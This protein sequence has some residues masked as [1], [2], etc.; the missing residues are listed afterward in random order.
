MSLE[1]KDTCDV[2]STPQDL[3]NEKNFLESE[4]LKKEKE[5]KNEGKESEETKDKKEEAEKDEAQKKL[6]VELNKV[7]KG[8]IFSSQI[9][10]EEINKKDWIEQ[11][12]DFIRKFFNL[13]S[14]NRSDSFYDQF[15]EGIR[16]DLKKADAE[17]YK[18]VPKKYNGIQESIVAGSPA[19]TIQRTLKDRTISDTGGLLNGKNYPPV[20]MANVVIKISG[21]EAQTVDARCGNPNERSIGI[22][23][24]YEGGELPSFIDYIQKNHQELWGAL[25]DNFRNIL[26]EAVKRKD[27]RVAFNKEN[28]GKLQKLFRDAAQQQVEFKASLIEDFVDRIHSIAQEYKVP[29]VAQAFLATEEGVGFLADNYNHLGPG[30]VMR[31]FRETCKALQGREVL[32]VMDVLQTYHQIYSGTKGRKDRMARNQNFMDS[33]KKV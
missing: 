6:E 13:G 22:F 18:G 8:E 15:D 9:P 24:F 25:D 27:F 4:N 19:E 16:S 1:A 11:I 32:T 31:F 29:S 28:L 5:Q 21:H 2:H 3:K 20:S 12:V 10:K 7:K 26:S 14:V 30:G 23:Q 17:Y 33:A